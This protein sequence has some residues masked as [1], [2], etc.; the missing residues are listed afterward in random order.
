M[1]I[2]VGTHVQQA[3]AA[4]RPVLALESTIITHG[5]PRPRNLQVALESQQQLRD[6]GVEP[7]TIGVVGGEPVVGLSEDELSALASDESVVKLS[8]RDLP[9]AAALDLSGGTTVAA[10][11][12]L[13]HAAGI[14]VFSTGGLGGVHRGA[15]AT[16]DVSAD[17]DA[18][19]EY[20]VVLV[21]AGVKS[22]LDVAATLERLETLSVPVLGWRT[23]HY[24]GFYIADSGFE[25]DYQVDTAEQ[26]AQI[27][28]A[29]DE[30]GLNSA[31]LIAR[32]IDAEFELDKGLHDRVLE[33]ALAQCDARGIHGHDITPF[34]LDYM[35]AH[36]AGE[37]LEANLAAYRGNLRLGG[38][39]AKALA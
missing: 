29:R 38:E 26:V 27:A 12:M 28:R 24:P 30:L 3:L 33:E 5:L 17:L 34:L 32:P 25:V 10:T 37:S 39:I 22:I 16:F 14:K 7:A 20:P 8:I 21:S 36:T 23:R 4:G 35:Q 1:A 18:L 19:A 9:I 13:A 2:R 11:A 31:V 6:Q 15:G